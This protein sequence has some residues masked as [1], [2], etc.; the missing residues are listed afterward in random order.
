MKNPPKKHGGKRLNAGKKPGPE[1]KATSRSLTLPANAWARI[2]ELRGQL[3]ASQW[4]AN[5]PRL[6]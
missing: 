3:S 2:D 4:L 5:D 6:S 1:G